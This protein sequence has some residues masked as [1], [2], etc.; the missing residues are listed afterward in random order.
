MR[1]VDGRVKKRIGLVA[2]R[3]RV[4]PKSVATPVPFSGDFRLTG[5]SLSQKAAEVSFVVW[6]TKDQIK[7]V[8]RGTCNPQSFLF[9]CKLIPNLMSAGSDE[10]ARG[11][12]TNQRVRVSN[13]CSSQWPFRVESE[14]IWGHL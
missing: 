1:G 8:F 9:K 4:V 11:H 13:T 7:P 10:Q 14:G 12:S 6:R 3:H 5:V 2:E